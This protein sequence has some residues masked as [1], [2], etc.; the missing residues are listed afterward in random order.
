MEN[1]V[2]HSLS[3]QNNFP[4]TVYKQGLGVP[5]RDLNIWLNLPEGSA[6]PKC[7][8]ITILIFKWCQLNIPLHF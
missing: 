1:K 8:I 3:N 2:C 6:G 4:I 5:C 7:R